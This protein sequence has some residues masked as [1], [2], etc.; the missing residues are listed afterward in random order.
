MPIIAQHTFGIKISNDHTIEQIVLGT[1]SNNSCFDKR[2]LAEQYNIGYPELEETITQL[3]Q[4]GLITCSD[5]KCCIDNDYLTS[6]STKL[7]MM[8]M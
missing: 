7:K 1:L 6:L 3:T 2:Q 8:S 4:F 5:K